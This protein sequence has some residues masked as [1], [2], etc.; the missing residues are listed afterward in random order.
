MNSKR[1]ILGCVVIGYGAMH[2]FG[3]MHAKWIHAC[4]YCKLIG[5]CEKDTEQ[6]PAILN[7]FPEIKIYKSTDEI[8]ADDVVNMVTIVTPNFTHCEL[9]KEA[10]TNGRHVLVE[11]AMALNAVECDEMVKAAKAANRSL[12]VHHNRRHDGNYRIIKELV[13]SGEIG[14]VFQIELSPTWYLNPFK[15]ATPELWW[16]DIKRSGGLFFY[17][18]SQAFDWILDLMPNRKIIGVNGFAQKRIWH[19]I[20][21]ED[22]VTAIVKFND[23]TVANFTESYIDASPRPFWR[24]LGTKGAIVDDFGAQIPGYQK[25][26]SAASCGRVKVFNGNIDGDTVQRYVAYK[27][28]DWNLFYCDL[29]KHILYGQKNPVPGEIGRRVLSIIDAAKKSCQSG[30]TEKVAFP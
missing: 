19:N 15:D 11:N 22:Q 20:T 6:Y 17:Y 18:G 30:E 23:G 24:I 3:W 28:S 25:Q 26:I 5:I 2:N 13:D 14:D 4:E 21:N 10:F 29:A 27:E 12:C 1:R 16:A 8:W 9:A 7:Y